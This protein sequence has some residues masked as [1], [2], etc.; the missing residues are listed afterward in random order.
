[1]MNAV[2]SPVSTTPLPYQLGERLLS[3]EQLC[4]GYDQPVLGDVTAHIDNITRDGVEQGQVVCLLGPSGIGKTQLFRCI[5]GLQKPSAGGVYLNGKKTPV[6]PGEVGVVAQ[7][8]P[9]LA[10]RTILGNLLVAASRKIT[11]QAEAKARAIELL[12][13]FGLADKAFCYPAALSGGQ[14]QRV[15]IAQQTLCSDHFLLMDEP[16]SGLDPIAKATVCD[17]ILQIST[18]DELNTIIVVSHDIDAS[19]S[20]ADT[21]WLLGRDYDKAGNPVSGARIKYR[22][23]LIERGLAW[24]RNMEN[25]AEFQ[26]LSREIRYRFKEL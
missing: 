17:M 4:V 1:M 16:F 11:N 8:Y 3:I 24:R 18:Q 10:H 26:A 19:I 12:N 7:D 15:A 21:I 9:L 23:D 5:A 13:N 14:R 25:T 22:Y 20:I 6:T 2:L